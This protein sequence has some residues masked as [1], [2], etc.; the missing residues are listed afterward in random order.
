VGDSLVK[1][2]MRDGLSGRTTRMGAY[3]MRDAV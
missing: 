1:R 2:N 3:S